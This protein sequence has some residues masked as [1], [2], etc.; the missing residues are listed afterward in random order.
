LAHSSSQNFA[1]LNPDGSTGSMESVQRNHEFKNDSISVL[2][3]ANT[4][5]PNSCDYRYDP[6]TEVSP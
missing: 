5:G 4:L 6:D 3:D 2:D 1:G